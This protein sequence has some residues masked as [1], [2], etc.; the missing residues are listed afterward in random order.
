MYFI[1]KDSYDVERNFPIFQK[2]KRSYMD[3]AGMSHHPHLA[4]RDPRGRCLEI[5]QPARGAH[6]QPKNT[7]RL[8]GP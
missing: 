8:Q 6:F 3:K 7:T 2:I 1:Q 4:S 5:M